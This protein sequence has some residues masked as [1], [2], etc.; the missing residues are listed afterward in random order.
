MSPVPDPLD[1]ALSR[2]LDGEAS[3][4]E[5]RLVEQRLASDPAAAAEV[6]RLRATVDAWRRDVSLP[7]PDGL[8]ARVLRT[9]AIGDD[10]RERFRAVSRRYAAAAA[11]L[12]AVGVGGTAWARRPVPP[13]PSDSAPSV[14]D[15]EEARLAQEQLAALGLQPSSGR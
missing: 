1:P 12:L 8:A 14:V 2:W 4:E 3:P 5:A 7:A 15:L 9:V 11:V 13:P 6:A 10:E